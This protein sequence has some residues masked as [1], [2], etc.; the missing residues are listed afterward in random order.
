MK[1][2]LRFRHVLPVLV[3]VAT[4]RAFTDFVFPDPDD[5]RLGLYNYAITGFSLLL[6]GWYFRYLSPVMRRWLLV[7]LAAT[8]AL[9]LESY[10]GW[11]TPLVYPHVFAKLLILL[12]IFALYAY[13]RRHPLPLPLFMGLLLGG[14]V[15][16]LA[17]YHP[18]ALSVSA[19]LE[20]ERG[21]DVTS[22][23]L[24]LLPALY[25]FNHYLTRGGLLRLAVFFLILGLIVFLQHRT[26][27]LTTALA[28]ALNGLLVAA[29]RVA[30]ARLSMP[31]LLPVVLMP[32]IA[33]LLG[34]AAL[35]LDNPQVLRRLETSLEDIEHADK[36]GTGSW[37]LHQ[38][39]T[40]L[41]FVEEHPVA[42]MRLE[43]F[44][45]PV[46]FY[47]DG[48]TPVWADRTG[49]HFH[50]FY[51]DRLFYFGVLGLL[52]VLAVPIGQLWKRA[53]QPVPFSG[54]TA[55]FVCYAGCSL[56]YG[57]SY[58]WPPYL[59]GLLGLTLALA[60]PAPI[61]APATSPAFGSASPGE[62]SV[63]LPYSAPPAP[64]PHALHS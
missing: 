44:E 51:L 30:G 54:A 12:P 56:L 20:N 52:L 49:H 29:G 23:F 32:L 17:F 59:Y 11:G 41:P 8:A 39:E 26:V 15:I 35:V 28:L 24:L 7:T 9:A 4:D 45:L 57:V 22:A 38:I 62:G 55:A 16:N 3:V 64:A 50:S 1:I 18:E 61:A 46:Q 25:H 53:R 42:G 34:G 40:Y 21:F 5:P 37:R 47:G 2:S 27:W 63:R 6:I 33:G 36:Q 13:Y 31:R 48:D 60:A 19:F 14:L 10:N 43:G 58:D